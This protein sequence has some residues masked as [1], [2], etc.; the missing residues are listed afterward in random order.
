MLRELLGHKD[1]VNAVALSADG[2]RIA[3]AGG[4]RSVRVWSTS[5]GEV[6]ACAIMLDLTCLISCFMS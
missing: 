5:D 2:S 6:A 1:R 3:S 4:D